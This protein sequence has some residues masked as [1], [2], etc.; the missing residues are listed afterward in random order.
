MK[1]IYIHHSANLGGA[2]KSL[3]YLIEGVSHYLEQ[4]IVTIYTPGKGAGTDFISLFSKNVIVDTRI[5]PFHNSVVSSTNSKTILKGLYGVMLAPLFV[6]SLL[7][8]K[9]D[10]IHLN[11]SCL[12]FYAP[13]IKFFSKKVKVICHLR[14]PLLNNLVSKIILLI[15]NKYTDSLIAI[16]NSEVPSTPLKN[17][18]II[19]NPIYSKFQKPKNIFIEN[20]NNKEITFTFMAR[21]NYENGIFDFIEAAR[22]FACKIE[23]NIKFAIIGTGTTDDPAILEMANGIS[24]LSTY[25]MTDNVNEHIKNSSCLI[26]PFKVPHFSRTLIEF[27]LAGVPAIVYDKDPINKIVENNHNGFICEPSL[28]SLMIVIENIANNPLILESI[29]KNVYDGFIDKYDSNTSIESVI[30]IYRRLV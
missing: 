2:P 23:F 22:L 27:G 20:F 15:L 18:Q 28:S 11:S 19:S 17:I 3:S 8:H 13:F 9:P 24:G 12:F 26:V 29:S 16:S 1:I 10:I 25:P 21:C 14:E 4:N 5:I 7:K 6:L 30:N